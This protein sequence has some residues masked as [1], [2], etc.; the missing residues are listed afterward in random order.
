MLAQDK[1]GVPQGGWVVETTIPRNSCRLVEPSFLFQVLAA[2]ELAETGPKYYPCQ[3]WPQRLFLADHNRANTNSDPA[4]VAHMGRGGY[5]Q[6]VVTSH[7]SGGPKDLTRLCPTP[8]PFCRLFS[9]TTTL[10][11]P[12]ST[13]ASAPR[14]LTTSSESQVV[15]I[16]VSW[17]VRR[18]LNQPQ[19][20][21]AFLKS[22]TAVPGL[23][24]VIPF[25][26]R[27]DFGFNDHT[28]NSAKRKKASPSPE[29]ATVSKPAHPRRRKREEVDSASGE[30]STAGSI[31][32]G[33]NGITEDE[34]SDVPVP[35][36]KKKKKATRLTT[37]VATAEKKKKKKSKSKRR[38]SRDKHRSPA[39]RPV[40][41]VDSDLVA[42][43][44]F[45]EQADA[46]GCDTL[47]L[48]LHLTYRVS[49]D[50]LSLKLLATRTETVV[51]QRTLFK[52]Q[53]LSSLAGMVGSGLALPVKGVITVRDQEPLHGTQLVLMLR[54][55]RPVATLHFPSPKPATAIDFHGDR[56]AGQRLEHAVAVAQALRPVT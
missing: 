23:A 16:P 33:T 11:L 35:Q 49:D 52:G 25:T 48:Q 7:L 1:P 32:S 40:E 5:F 9:A 56:E 43:C 44:C 29:P 26:G 37:P 38:S 19:K 30:E 54:K 8:S 12:M 28:R 2:A 13:T 31:E 41:L 51:A 22:D 27:V 10:L 24:R 53:G 46:E 6:S 4:R 55:G 36:P 3:P 50:S 42:R 21:A 39:S 47:G 20:T 34:D 14:P 15:G 45:L 18:F 17:V